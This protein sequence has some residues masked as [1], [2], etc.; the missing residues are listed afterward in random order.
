MKID[1]EGAELE[2]LAGAKRTVTANP[3]IALIVE[4]DSAHIRRSSQSTDGWVRAFER[5]GLEFGVIH[6]DLGRLE[7]WTKE[8]IEHAG[9]VNLFFA[10]PDSQV[11]E[12]AW[13]K[14]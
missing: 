8:Q 12:R 10:R 14:Q 4:F 11:W 6:P 9:T 5:F 7:H 2:V 13:G 1:V 3:E